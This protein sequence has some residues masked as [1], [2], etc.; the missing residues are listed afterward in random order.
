[1]VVVVVVVGVEEV[2]EEEPV[3]VVVGWCSMGPECPEQWEI[4]VPSDA[5]VPLVKHPM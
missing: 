5:G 4:S 3:V 2:E 1:M